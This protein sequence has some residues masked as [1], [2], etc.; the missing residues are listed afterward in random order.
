V[1]FS[2]LQREVVSTLSKTH[3]GGPLLVGSL[4]SVY[5]YTPSHRELASSNFNSY[6]WMSAG[7]FVTYMFRMTRVLVRTPLA[8]SLFVDLFLCLI[9]RPESRTD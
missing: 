3:D 8:N 9:I 5:S 7:S 4:H 6:R 1:A 2:F